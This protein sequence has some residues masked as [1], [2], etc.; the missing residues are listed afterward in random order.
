ME[1]QNRIGIFRQ[2]QNVSAEYARLAREDEAAANVLAESGCY[3]HATYFI[4]QAIEKHLRAKIFEIAD[5]ASEE[6]RQANRN[7]SVE[8]A[9]SYLVSTFKETSLRMLIQE[10]FDAFLFRG[11]RFNLLHND[12]RYPT[13]F[14][15]RA[16]FS[17]LDIQK[18][19]LIEMF[20]RVDWLKDF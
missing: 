14:E 4:V 18:E 5:P 17:C 1:L 16:T 6:V 19:D 11:L 15:Q 8:D 12:V 7:H 2:C 3:R 13:Y 20:D 10:Q 9:V